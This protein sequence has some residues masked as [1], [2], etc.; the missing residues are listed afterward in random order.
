MDFSELKN[1]LHNNPLKHERFVLIAKAALAVIVAAFIS[2]FWLA[3]ATFPAGTMYNLKQG[4]TYSAVADDLVSMHIIK[5]KFWFKSFV[6]LFAVGERKIIAGDYSFPNKEENVLDIAWRLSHGDFETKS[7]KIT[8]PEGLNSSEIADIYA[9]NLPFFDKQKFLDIVTTK[10]LEG[11]LFPDTYFFMPSTNEQAI[12]DLM[13]SNYADKIAPLAADIK[14]SGHS[15][16]DIIT[17]ASILEEEART[18]EDRKIVAG[19][20][21]KR[22]SLGMALQVDSSFKYINGKTTATLTT[23]DLK[24]D[25]PYNTYTHRGL[26]PT[27]I[28][29]PGLE[30]IED[31]LNPTKTPYL[32]FLS[33]NDGNM[34]YAATLDEHN[35]NKA[36]YLND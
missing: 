30:T 36:K 23:D 6:Y 24:I 28:S 1:F 29:N 21:W 8:I 4:E 3:P 13:T 22:I 16:A 34:H 26:P 9:K 14:K 31:A 19:I 17:M 18:T 20:L 27:A 25:S 15:E 11:Y 33:G 7:V 10:K 32:Y 12:I 2:I 35:A 5:S